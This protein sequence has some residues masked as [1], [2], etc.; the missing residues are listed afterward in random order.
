MELAILAFCVMFLFIASGGLILFYREAMLKRIAA[1]VTPPV[2]QR[3]LK[4][5][6][7]QTGLSLCIVVEQFERILPKS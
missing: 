7:Q 6:L 4:N 2:K 1:V 5:T 3:D